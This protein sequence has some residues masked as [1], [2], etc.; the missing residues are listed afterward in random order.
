MTSSSTKP[1]AIGVRHNQGECD[2]TSQ[3][4]RDSESVVSVRGDR[5]ESLEVWTAQGNQ[6]READQNPR[7]ELVR[8]TACQAVTAKEASK[9][10]V[11]VSSGSHGRSSKRE[12]L[13]AGAVSETWVASGR[14]RTFRGLISPGCA[15][16]VRRSGKISQGNSLG[17]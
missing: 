17:F 5:Q 4:E 12:G 3:C 8:R 9:E 14:H 2:D 6:T 1:E 11:G 16:L 10:L 15:A 7:G 13:G